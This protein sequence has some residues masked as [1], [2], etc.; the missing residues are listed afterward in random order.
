[1]S[2]ES[3]AVNVVNATAVE[4]SEVRVQMSIASDA[5]VV[6]PILVRIVSWYIYCC[7]SL[8]LSLIT[9]LNVSC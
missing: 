2:I 7:L 3:A 1:M 6:G 8:R 5:V 9:K 4:V